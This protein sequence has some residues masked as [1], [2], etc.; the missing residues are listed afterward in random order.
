MMYN[1]KEYIKKYCHDRYHRRKSEHKCVVCGEQLEE[2]KKN[3]MCDY[4][5]QKQK[6]S[7]RR[8]YQKRKLRAALCGAKMKGGAK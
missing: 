4:C 3:T 8:Y 2:S 1:H 6:D 7:Q 5:R